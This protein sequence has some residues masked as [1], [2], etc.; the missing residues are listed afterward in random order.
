MM[1]P[2]YRIPLLKKA[3]HGVVVNIVGKRQTVSC[4]HVFKG[5]DMSPTRLL[6]CNV[7]IEQVSA[8]I[9]KARDEIELLGDIW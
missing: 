2:P 4:A 7:C 6:L 8:V 5:D 1:L 3:E 9:I